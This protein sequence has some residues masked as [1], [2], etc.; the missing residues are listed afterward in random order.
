MKSLLAELKRRNVF[1]VGVAYAVVGWVILQFVD[2][3]QE[4]LNLPEWFQ[5]VVIVLVAIG[6][7][8]ALVF[9]W[10]YELTPQGLKKTAEARKTKSVTPKTGG[11]IN[12]V[13]AVGLALTVGFIVYDKMIVTETPV[14]TKAEAGQT[15]IAVLP[16]VNM[17][18]D[19]E[20]EFFSDGITE[21]IL[22]VLA[23]NRALKVAGR[24]SS[25][26]Y[27]GKDM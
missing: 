16:F 5:K 4:P 25:F 17:S 8:I 18:S 10:A 11:R 3:V 23:K 19:P 13:I 2:I 15:A 24:T 1:K 7:P 21:E 26:A 22:N 14:V 27:K 12:K 9:S 20:Q 6:F